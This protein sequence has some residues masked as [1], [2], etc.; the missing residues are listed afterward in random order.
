MEG[1]SEAPAEAGID[2]VITDGPIPFEPEGQR[3]L[4][5]DDVGLAAVGAAIPADVSLPADVTD[6]E[7]RLTCVVL[8][9]VVRLRRESREG[10]KER[11]QLARLA[12]TDP[13]TGLANRRAWD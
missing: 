10:A 7:L 5:R 3:R 1:V 13:L 2:V 12:F 8:A 9:E 4:S 11:Q 6:R